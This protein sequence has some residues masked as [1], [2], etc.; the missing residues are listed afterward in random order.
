[1][2]S[3]VMLEHQEQTKVEE[4]EEATVR[5]EGLEEHLEQIKEE[6]ME[7]HQLEGLLLLL[8]LVNQKMRMLCNC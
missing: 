6:G 4:E 1:M 5:E 3:G 8:L 7:E 2:A